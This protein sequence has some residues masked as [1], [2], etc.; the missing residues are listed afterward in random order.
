[1]VLSAGCGVW[2]YQFLIIAY[3]FTVLDELL[4][5]DCVATNVLT[6]KMQEIMDQVL[7]ICDNYDLTIRKKQNGVGYSQHLESPKWSQQS[8]WLDTWYNSP[9]F[10]A[11]RLHQCHWLWG[12][13]Q[14]C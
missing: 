10:E 12:H 13:C 14:N 4:Y 9:I 3:L 8:Q 2:L 1:M 5:A 11:L 7:Q 6:E